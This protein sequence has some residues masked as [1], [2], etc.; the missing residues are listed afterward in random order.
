MKPSR[1]EV[2]ELI[3]ANK[4][5]KSMPSE[6]AFIAYK[7]VN[8]YSE[9]FSKYR[10]VILTLYIPAGAKRYQDKRYYYDRNTKLRVSGAYVVAAEYRNGEKPKTKRFVP[11]HCAIF[12]ARRLQG[13]KLSAKKIKLVKFRWVVGKWHKPTFAW[14]T[15]QDQCQSGLHAYISKVRAR[16]H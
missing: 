14:S 4:Q 7:R 6:G 11:P 10:K 2:K 15:S 5:L 8:E 16:N 9:G 12:I 3:R 13:V 1:K